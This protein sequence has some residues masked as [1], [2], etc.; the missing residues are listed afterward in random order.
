MG[1]EEE[2]KYE[3]WLQE[4]GASQL[5]ESGNMGKRRK[6]LQ[7]DSYKVKVLKRLQKV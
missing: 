3:K 2:G 7:R 5:Q 4:N 1:E 6:A